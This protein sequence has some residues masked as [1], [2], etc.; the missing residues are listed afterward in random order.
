MQHQAERFTKHAPRD[1]LST[2][3]AED[4]S[5]YSLYLYQK[6]Y[7]RIIAEADIIITPCHDTGVDEIYENF[8]PTVGIVNNCN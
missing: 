7:F 4:E 8:Q 1:L 5:E 2:G 6:I 3:R